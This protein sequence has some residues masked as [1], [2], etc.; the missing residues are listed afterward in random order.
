MYVCMYVQVDLISDDCNKDM[1][2][3][4]TGSSPVKFVV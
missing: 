3:R 2:S 4:F 1:A